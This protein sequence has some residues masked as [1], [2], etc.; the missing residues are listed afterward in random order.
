VL[1]GEIEQGNFRTGGLL[2]GSGRQ[3]IATK[4]G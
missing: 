2:D 3:Q 1:G 4:V